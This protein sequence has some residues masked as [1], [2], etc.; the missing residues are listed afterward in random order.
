MYKF[1]SGNSER[2]EVVTYELLVH[3]SRS[4]LLYSRSAES[5]G[6]SPTPSGLDIYTQAKRLG[7]F[8]YLSKLKK[9]LTLPFLRPVKV[10]ILIVYFLLGGI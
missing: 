3:H 7:F 6:K 5:D 1:L 4:K 2:I 8:R 10:R 9:E